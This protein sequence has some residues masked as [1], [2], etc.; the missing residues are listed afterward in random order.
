MAK[1][2]YMP[3]YY[4]DLRSNANWRRSSWEAK[5]VWT[6]VM[7]L[8]HDS[9][10]Y[11]IL[12]WPLKDIAEAIGAPIKILKE[13]INK[14]VLKGV[15]TLVE[16]V[17]FSTSISQKNSSPVEVNLIENQVGPLWFSSRM[18][19]DEY[20]RQKKAV[21]GSKSAKNNAVPRKK[22]K[23]EESEEEKKRIPSLSTS[24]SLS[25]SDINNKISNTP[26]HSDPREKKSGINFEKSSEQ[27]AEEALREQT[28]FT[29]YRQILS[30]VGFRPEQILKTETTAMITAWINAG[31]G[32]DIARTEIVAL[33]TKLGGLPGGPKYYFEQVLR[34][35]KNSDEMKLKA[36]E[37][38]NATPNG[39]ISGSGHRFTT[40]A[41]RAHIE[42]AELRKKYEAEAKLEEEAANS[43]N[44]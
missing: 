42:N 2:P 4:S 16:K 3:L 17:S 39:K 43:E 9:D 12:R 11:G 1:R 27:L 38:K 33:N 13:L 7:G 29:S 28:I 44:I 21:H 23:E 19:R 35:K 37:I 14:G 10:E 6:E 25:L 40:P 24:L 34:A 22:I 31:V 5:G 18:V 8:M 15:D 26:H 20:V 32:E 41:E 30:D 36:E